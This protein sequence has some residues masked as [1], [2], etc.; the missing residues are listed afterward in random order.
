MPLEHSTNACQ[1]A[2]DGVYFHMKEAGSGRPVVCCV[3]FGAISAIKTG[4]GHPTMDKLVQRFDLNRAYF[5]RLV[6]RKYD[7]RRDTTIDATDVEMS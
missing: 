5:E 4:F 6:S 2:N 3:K 1:A 7:A